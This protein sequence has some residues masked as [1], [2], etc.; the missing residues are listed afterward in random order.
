MSRLFW[1]CLLAVSLGVTACY[2]ALEPPTIPGDFVVSLSFSQNADLGKTVD[3]PRPVARLGEIAQ[4]SLQARKIA[5]DGTA[6]NDDGYNGYICLYISRGLL[7][8]TSKAVKLTNG[9]AE[10][11]IRIRLAFGKTTIW[12]GEV[13]DDPRSPGPNGVPVCPDSALPADRTRPFVG[14]SGASP[15]IYYEL[16]TVAD[17]QDTD[18]SSGD[19]PLYKRQAILGRGNM[20]VTAVTNNGFYVTDLDASKTGFQYASAF[21]FTFSAPSLAFEDGEAPRLLKVGERIFCIQ[22]GVDEFSGHTQLTFPSFT[23]L[24]LNGKVEC[25]KPPPAG[26]DGVIQSV[27]VDQMPPPIQIGNDILWTRSKMEP[28]ES[29]IVEVKNVVAIPF[30]QSQDGWQEFRQWPVLMV[31]ATRPEDQAACEEKI[32]TELM[33]HNDPAKND[34]AKSVYRTALKACFDK[35]KVAEDACTATRGSCTKDAATCDTELE[36]CK[37]AVVD[38]WYTCFFDQRFKNDAPKGLFPRLEEYV[39]TGGQSALGCSY[40]IMLVVSN[41]TV[42]ELDV[43]VP[44]HLNRRFLT[45]RGVLQQ[46]KASAYYELVGGQYP[47]ELSNNGYVILVR[48]SDDIQIEPK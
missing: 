29:A 20:V 9:R 7:E 3:S 13:K 24:W 15:A 22:G 18:A 16:L 39:P 27:P 26:S 38:T 19:S 23:P 43:T 31:E 41:A 14:Q 10:S 2:S 45:I 32:R 21:I 28:Y 33:I 36:D 25:G 4:V 35:R 5:P 34:L 6:S 48:N 46:T 1:M 17:L 47:D 42:P 37:T 8:G 12:A 30:S 40:G 44:E 11:P